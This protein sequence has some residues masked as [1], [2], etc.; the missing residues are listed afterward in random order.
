MFPKLMK[1]I[2]Q[3]NIGEARLSLRFTYIYIYISLYHHFTINFGMT[4][5]TT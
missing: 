1:R 4:G 2:E 3:V 5:M